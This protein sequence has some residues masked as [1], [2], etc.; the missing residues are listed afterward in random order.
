MSPKKLN[1]LL[2]QKDSL[3]LGWEAARIKINSLE[4]EIVSLRSDT[5]ILQDLMTVTLHYVLIHLL[6]FGSF[7][8]I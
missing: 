8:M 1:T 3:S 4:G 5:A 7:R 6:K 2:A